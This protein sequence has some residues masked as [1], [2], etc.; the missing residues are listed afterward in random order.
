MYVMHND[1]LIFI[2]HRS[3]HFA[4]MFHVTVKGGSPV[5]NISSRRHK[6]SEGDSV[7]RPLVPGGLP[8]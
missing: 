4:H 8:K 1:A 2:F 5:G 6:M 7:L 3:H